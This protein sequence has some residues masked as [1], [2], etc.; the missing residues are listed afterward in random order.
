MWQAAAGPI[1][2]SFPGCQCR[3][4]SIGGHNMRE[5]HGVEMHPAPVEPLEGFAPIAKCKEG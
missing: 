4:F 3:L 1:P 2:T 5:S